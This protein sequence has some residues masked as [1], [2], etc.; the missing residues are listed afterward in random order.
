MIFSENCWWR[1]CLLRLMMTPHVFLG[2]GS[3]LIR[4][5][6]ILCYI[7]A[8]EV[9]AEERLK[10][11]WNFSGKDKFRAL[12]TNQPKEKRSSNICFTQRLKPRFHTWAMKIKISWRSLMNV[13]SISETSRHSSVVWQLFSVTDVC[14][15]QEQLFY[16]RRVHQRSPLCKNRVKAPLF[17]SSVTWQR[18]NPS[19]F[20]QGHRGKKKKKKAD[21]FDGW[22]MLGFS[23]WQRR[24]SSLHH[25][26]EP[27]PVSVLILRKPQTWHREAMWPWSESHVTM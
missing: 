12:T 23:P 9:F 22:C 17:M 5:R 21:S 11:V 15:T 19:Q 2:P 10:C 7:K 27:H 18:I 24:R 20:S 3:A 6:K 13:R 16:A 25:C 1:S 14:E 26:S 4:R 8:A